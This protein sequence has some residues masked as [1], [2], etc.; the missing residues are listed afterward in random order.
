MFKENV[1]FPSPILVLAKGPCQL[2]T[3]AFGNNN[4]KGS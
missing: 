4:Y 3:S 2:R 1:G